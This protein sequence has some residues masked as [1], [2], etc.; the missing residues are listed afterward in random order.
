MRKRLL[1]LFQTFRLRD[2]F[3]P[4]SGDGENREGGP[5]ALAVGGRK[6][7]RGVGEPWHDLLT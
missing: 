7:K 3:I 6:A 2:V 4:T 1:F 5:V